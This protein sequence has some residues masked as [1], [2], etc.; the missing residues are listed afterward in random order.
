MYKSAGLLILLCLVAL[1]W[2]STAAGPTFQNAV[3]KTNNTVVGSGTSASCTSQALATALSGG[4]EI[5]FDCGGAATILLTNAN[6]ITT[7]ATLNGG[8]LIT[9]SGG[10]STRLF[11]ISN[12]TQL[13]LHDITL[14]NGFANADG[15]AIFVSGGGTLWVEGSTFTGNATF[16]DASGGAIINYGTVSVTNSSFIDNSGGN[17]GAIYP[18]W[19]GS[20]TLIQ[21]SI[22]RNNRA[23][24]INSGWGGAL[25]IW[26]GAQVE[27][28]NSQ[29][30][31]NTARS[32]GAIYNT[33]PSDHTHD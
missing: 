21:N 25:L 31:A 1:A 29:F 2:V 27:I 4:G 30:I 24:N 6:V 17:G 16:N 14:S 8:G 22:F 33:Q 10:N 3:A 28:L 9:L 19:G 32:G 20:R 15:G 12:A 26:D 5:T 7:T 13:T 18:R 23:V 11:V